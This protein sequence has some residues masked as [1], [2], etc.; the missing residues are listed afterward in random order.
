MSQLL[1]SLKPEQTYTLSVGDREIRNF[2]QVS[3]WEIFAKFSN[4][5]SWFIVLQGQMEKALLRCVGFFGSQEAK[6]VVV[7]CSLDL[8]PYFVEKNDERNVKDEQKAEAD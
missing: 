6:T 8:L 4:G 2:R 5:E 7:A 3:E 1:T